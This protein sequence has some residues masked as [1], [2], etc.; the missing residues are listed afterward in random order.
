MNVFFFVFFGIS[1]TN[2]TFVYC[3]VFVICNVFC[4]KGGPDL[5]KEIDI[6]RDCNSEY[7]VQYKGTFY[8]DGN[9]WVSV[10]RTPL[11]SGDCK[12]DSISMWQEC[13]WVYVFFVVYRP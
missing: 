3:V 5:Q 11:E 9:I 1:V 2:P 6:L 4:Q 13:M 8:K 7:V 12:E 10:W